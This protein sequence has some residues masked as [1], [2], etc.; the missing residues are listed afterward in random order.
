MPALSLV[1]CLYRERDLFE[2]LLREMAGGYDD[3]VVVHDGPEDGNGIAKLVAQHGG[4]FFTRPRA[5]QQEPHWPFAWQEA[6]HDWILRLDADEVPGPAMKAWL[7]TFRAAREP[8]PPLSG[9]TCIWPLWDG[10]RIVTNK[11]PAGRHF[12]FHKRRV[13]FFGMV[14]QVPVADGRFEPVP[15][16][17]EHRPPRK[18]YGLSNLLLRAQA[19]HWRRVI[20]R[21][22]LGKPTDLACWRWG[23]DAWP[24]VWEEIRR[25]PLRTALHRLLIWPLFALRD[26]WRTEGRLIPAA[27]ISGGIHHCLIALVYWRMRRS[28]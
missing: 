6:R 16:I 8:E 7:Q 5:F 18:S 26:I 20:A 28:A 1:V 23:T 19:Y 24:T 22:L 9:Y 15:L 12:V 2:R 25:R 3:L 13:R 21:S 11:W 10:R 14:E 4:R 17:L 27:A